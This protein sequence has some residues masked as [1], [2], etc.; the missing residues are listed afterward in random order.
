M[1]TLKFRFKGMGN[2]W[3]ITNHGKQEEVIRNSEHLSTCSAFYKPKKT[4]KVPQTMSEL[5]IYGSV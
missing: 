1:N 5:K 4:D 2:V 3:G